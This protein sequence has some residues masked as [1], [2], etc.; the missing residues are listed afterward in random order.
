MP[1]VSVIMAAYNGEEYIAQ[2][3][4]SILNQTYKDFEIVIV[5][6]GSTDKTKEIVSS[7]MN[8][9][10]SNIRYVYQ[11]NG[12]QSSARNRGIREAKG[13]FVA[14]LDQDDLWMP[15]FLERVVGKIDEGF[16]WV[17]SDNFRDGIDTQL[18]DCQQDDSEEGT[19][20]RLGCRSAPERIPD[21]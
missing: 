4:G 21:R 13:E 15:E 20:R 2:A 19:V 8:N 5:D 7:F 9:A 18:R 14:F 16:D 6:D 12:G 11:D 3:L 10:S 1:R 17:V